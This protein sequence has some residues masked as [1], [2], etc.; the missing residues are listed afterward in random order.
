MFKSRTPLPLFIFVWLIAVFLFFWV[1]V[2][3]STRHACAA[4]PE[5]AKAHQRTLTRT[6]HAYWGLDAPVATFAAQIHQESRWHVGARSPVGAEGLAQFMPATSEWFA[7]INPR[8]L[9]VAQPYNPAWA[10]RAQVMYNAW[11][12]KRITA[13]DGCNRL[14]FTLSAYNGGLGW[15]QRDQALASASGADGLVYT[16][17]EPFNAGRSPASITENR[18]YVNVILKRWQPM[19]VKAGWGP[20]ACYAF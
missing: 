7:S 16:S 20:G 18:H 4:V 3:L 8:D 11:L 9:T 14:A 17:V 19:Y 2:L 5:A 15:V 13:A 6:A 1:V 10:M 12:Y